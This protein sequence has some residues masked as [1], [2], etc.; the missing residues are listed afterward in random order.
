ML[1]PLHVFEQRYR[2]MLA[3]ILPTPAREFVVLLIREGD[4]VVESPAPGLL[5]GGRPPSTYPVGTVARVVEAQ[6]LGDGRYFLVCSGTERV[7]LLAQTQLEP[8][9]MGRFAPVP[10]EPGGNQHRGRDGGAHADLAAVVARTQQAI[11]SVFEA[12]L[13]R[14]PVERA[15][16]RREVQR[17]LDAIPRDAGPLSFFVPRVLFTASNAEKQRLL[18]APGVLA[19]LQQALPLVLLE[20]RLAL[21]PGGGPNHPIRPSPN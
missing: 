3:D 14:L 17:I 2:Q 9:P 1:L 21:Q 11:R 13:A 5:P 6:A 19:R 18:E 10:D 16:Q 15:D 12:V 7:R 4:E 20:E 8:Y